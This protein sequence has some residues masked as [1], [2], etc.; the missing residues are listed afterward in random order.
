M[1]SQK[2]ID[3]A[4]EELNETEEVK[5]KAIHEFRQWISAHD[6]FR[7]SRKGAKVH[8]KISFIILIV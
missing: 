3:K 5:T 6:F 1:L 4:R 8:A 7:N 2:Y